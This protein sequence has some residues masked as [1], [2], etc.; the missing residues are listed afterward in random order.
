MKQI[1]LLLFLFYL[2][3]TLHSQTEMR[4]DHPEKIEK[5]NLKDTLEANRLYN[6]SLETMFAGEFDSASY[7]IRQSIAIAAKLRYNRGLVRGYTNLGNIYNYKGDYKPALD[8]YFLALKLQG[9][10]STRTTNS[11]MNGIALIYYKIDN[12]PEALN[13]HFKALKLSEQFSDSMGI[14]SAYTNIGQV[15]VEQG[16][17]TSAIV[18][19]NK[20]LSFFIRQR[21]TLRM[22]L[23]FD[24][25][26]HVYNKRHDRATAVRYF[27][28]ELLLAK[29]TDNGDW[30]AKAYIGMYVL[31]PENLDFALAIANMSKAME[32]KQ[33]MEDMEGVAACLFLL[34]KLH[35]AQKDYPKAIDYLSRGNALAKKMEVLSDIGSTSQL[36]S[37][38]YEQQKDYKQ[39]LAYYKAY[40]QAKDSIFNDANTKKVM[41]A[42]LNYEFEKKQFALEQEQLKKE[43]IALEVQ[44][45]Q[46]LVIWAIGGLSVLLLIIAFLVIRQVR[47]KNRA[48]EM[49]LEQKLLRSQM[50]PHFIFN[51][52]QA[53]QNFVLKHNEKDAVKYLSSFA[54]IT[55]SVLENSR[56]ESIPLRK[57]LALL[58][59]YLQLQKLRFENEFDYEIRFDESLD[60]DDTY[61]PPMLAQPFIENAL[62]HGMKHIEGGGLIT[63][64]F[65]KDNNYL[66]LEV[67]DNGN[68]IDKQH[69][70]SKTHASLATVITQERIRLMNRK[71]RS[72]IRFSISDAFPEKDRKGVKV[73]FSI[74]LDSIA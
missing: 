37:Q 31:L 24:C 59:N 48:R 7:F 68:G 66:H 21:D 49:L 17:D 71:S 44:K 30:E 53:I 65:S 10:T 25:L 1:S 18:N 73:N 26:G 9:E 27:E 54:A 74:P 4:V 20:A 29:A 69:A 46:Q 15:Y 41:Q 36:L 55:R 57:E 72:A 52:L 43:A 64:S 38:A 63:I 61:I 28:Q 62:E 12:Y 40:I 42:E 19:Y 14:Y 67:R 39:A 51:S 16:K 3:A 6:R 58:G 32:I 45:K 60:I 70:G 47:Y 22:S 11:I 2:A 33:D 50:N 5:L 34:G 8:N 13:Y 56:L 23:L 35:A